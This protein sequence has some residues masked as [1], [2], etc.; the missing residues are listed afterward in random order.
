M[1]HHQANDH[2]DE[3]NPYAVPVAVTV[4]PDYEVDFGRIIRQWE[5]LR[6]IYNGV[7]AFFVLLFTF[8]VHPERIVD[9]RYWLSVLFG[10][11]VSNVCFFLGPAFEGYGRFFGVW[12]PR[13]TK[14]LFY[15]GLVFTALM[16]VLSVITYK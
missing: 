3:E 15:L 10:A 9:L 4:T 14:I 13:L 1:S 6:V 8:T 16:A 5:G 12:A 11:F 7:L 2:S